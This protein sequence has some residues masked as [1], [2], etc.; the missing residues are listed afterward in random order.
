[1]Q[2][3]FTSFHTP[4]YAGYAA[5]LTASL[6]AHGLSHDCRAIAAMPTWII[7]CAH[8][9]AH[10]LAVRGKYPAT[11]LVWLDADAQVMQPPTHFQTLAADFDFAAYF[12]HGRGS[13][14]RGGELFSGTL[15]LN[16]TPAATE[17]LTRWQAQCARTPTKIDQQILQQIVE[18]MPGLRYTGLH[19]TFCFVEAFMYS[20]GRPAVIAHGMA[21]RD[22]APA[23]RGK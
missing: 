1:M 11:P 13:P 18:S 23:S 5:A 15:W 16:S 6:D 19:K 17:L 22:K 10:L 8:K 14:P 12:H 2:P 4:D 7:A 3:L 9:P 21:S 20:P